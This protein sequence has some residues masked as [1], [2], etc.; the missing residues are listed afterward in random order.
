MP[1]TH[2]RIAFA[3]LARPT[4]DLPLAQEITQ[5]AIDQLGQAGF[6]LLTPD[7]LIADLVGVQTFL[8]KLNGAGNTGVDLLLILQA[9][10]ADSTLVTSLV[11]G[12]SSFTTPPPVFLWAVPEPR[13]GGRLRL[14]SLCGI[15]LAGH[16]LS[17]REQGY[18]YAYAQPGDS[19]VL[20][21][22]KTLA[23]AGM[24]RRRLAQTRLGV[25][26]EHPAGMDSC[27]LDQTQLKEKLGIS[28]SACH[29]IRFFLWPARLPLSRLLLYVSYWIPISTISLNWI[30][31]HL[32]V[33]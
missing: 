22:I 33:H 3:A 31:N 21:Q 8:S 27:H 4:F 32:T 26:G 7:D 20:Q 14:N 5:Q 30:K 23:A 16:A 19:A 11:E 1:N 2:F 12:L 24:L 13:T 6:E 25:V 29:L 17:Q 18:E 15:N 9:T 10:F 28:V